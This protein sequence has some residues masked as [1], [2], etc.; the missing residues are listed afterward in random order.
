MNVFHPWV[1]LNNQHIQVRV[2][3]GFCENELAD[4]QV[5]IDDTD[6]EVWDLLDTKNQRKVELACYADHR[7]V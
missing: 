5:Y 3:Y 6:F 7:E 1:D 2:E 4:L